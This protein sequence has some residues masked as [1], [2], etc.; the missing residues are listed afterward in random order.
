MPVPP[1]GRRNAPDA[2]VT[3]TASWFDTTT[4]DMPGSP[5]SRTPFAF[6]SRNTTPDVAG[7]CAAREAASSAAREKPAMG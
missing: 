3:A 2:S 4:P 1:A 6:A 5:A 7:G